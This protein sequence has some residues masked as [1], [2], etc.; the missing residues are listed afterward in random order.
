MKNGLLYV[1]LT[2]VCCILCSFPENDGK[3]LAQCMNDCA[4][5]YIKEKQ[6]AETVFVSHF[7]PNDYA[8][9]ALALEAYD[10]AMINVL[11]DYNVRHDE[12]DLAAKALY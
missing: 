9:R 12:V 6:K 11:G 2:A 10:Q 1:F 8:T 3:K 4:E 5:T 7:N